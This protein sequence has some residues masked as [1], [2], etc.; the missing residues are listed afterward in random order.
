MIGLQSFWYLLLTEAKTEGATA[1]KLNYF[2]LHF[3]VC[4]KKEERKVGRAERHEHVEG[5]RV[6]I[7]LTYF[8]NK[9]SSVRMENRIKI[10]SMFT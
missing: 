10:E 2:I 5:T 3:S 7:S 1:S 9:F 8:V 6:P 4:G